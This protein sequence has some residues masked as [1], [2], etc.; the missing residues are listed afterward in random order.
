[1]F[2]LLGIPYIITKF[3][4]RKLIEWRGEPCKVKDAKFYLIVDGYGN[5]HICHFTKKYFNINFNAENRLKGLNKKYIPTLFSS[6]EIS[7][8]EEYHE[9]FYVYN[10][11][12]CYRKRPLMNKR[13]INEVF[14]DGYKNNINP[15]DNDSLRNTNNRLN[16]FYNKDYYFEF[17]VFNLSRTTNNDIYYFFCIYF[18]ILYCWNDCFYY[19][20]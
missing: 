11:Y 8:K 16:I 18:F 1:M 10:K 5:Y 20:L 9:I 6:I 15:I 14:D 12:Y 17:P 19:Y 2:L 13:N 7:D 4:N 3:S